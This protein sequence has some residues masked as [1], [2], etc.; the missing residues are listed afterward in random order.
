MQRHRN[1]PCPFLCPYATK[2]FLLHSM[3]PSSLLHITCAR[4]KRAWLE[5]QYGSPDS[6]KTHSSSSSF[7]WLVH[8]LGFVIEHGDRVRGIFLDEGTQC[9]PRIQT[10][11]PWPSHWVDLALFASDTK[12]SDGLLWAPAAYE[13]WHSRASDCWGT[14]LSAVGAVVFLQQESPHS[15][16]VLE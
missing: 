9:S 16:F 1:P 2:N 11:W 6:Q 13:F 10:R 5:L 8:H 3:R 15:E 4:W 14:P 12:H 7:S